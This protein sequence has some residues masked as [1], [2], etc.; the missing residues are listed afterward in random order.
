LLLE[1][2]ERLLAVDREQFGDR[3]SRPLFHG[4]VTVHERHA[5]PLGQQFSDRALTRTGRADNHC[6]WCHD[7]HRSRRV[8]RYDSTLRP[9]SVN[10]SPPNFSVA[11]SASTSA[12]TDSSTTPARGTAQTSERWWIAAADSP[13]VTSTVAS[14]RGTV[15]IG[16]I[17]TR[18]R[19]GSPLLIPPSIPPAR[20][21]RLLNPLGAG[22]RSI[23]SCAWLPQ[24]VAVANPSP[25]C[26]PFIA[27]T[28]INAPASRA[29]SLRSACTCEPRPGGTPYAIT[30]STPP[31]VSP[32][33]RTFSTSDTIACVAASPN[34]R[35]GLSSMLASSSGPGRFGSSD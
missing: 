11:A 21:E 22:P 35:T 30:S 20:L 19:S 8:C 33:F 1:F 15:E 7:D 23:S 34:A 27:C 3:L 13:V 12:S 28:P 14:A 16:F 18:T 26:T 9:L 31:T 10:E 4:R 24:R 32:A 2:P 29:S 5:E 25:T 17:A 6:P